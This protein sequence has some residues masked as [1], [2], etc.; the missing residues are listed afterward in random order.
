M[1]QI[2]F[3]ILMIADEPER[4]FQH[5]HHPQTEQVH[6]D[7]AQIGAVFFIPLQHNS[8]RHGR[9]FQRHD[10]IKLSLADHHAAGMLAEVARQILHRNTQLEILA[11]AGMIQIQASI[12]EMMVKRVVCVPILPVGNRRRNFIQRLRIEA[13]NLAH[14]A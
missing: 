12:A 13:Q 14:F 10:R 1:R 3:F 7:D 4:I 9:R 5:R 8:A 2:N 6:F 11:Q